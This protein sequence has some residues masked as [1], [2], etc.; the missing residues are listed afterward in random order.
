M[1]YLNTPAT[2]CEERDI[3]GMWKKARN[4]EIENF[5]GVDAPFDTPWSSDLRFNT[6]ELSVEHCVEK[7]I[8]I[9]FS[10]KKAPPASL[11]IGRYQ[12]LHEGHIKLIGVPLREGKRVVIALRDTQ[13]TKDNPHTIHE[14]IQ[15]FREAF[16]NDFN[17]KLTIISIPDILDVCHG[18]RVGW[19]IREI[20]MDKSTEQISATKIREEAAK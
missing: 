13:L 12:P 1:V 15:M 16:P 4:K 14:R 2:V 3:K 18:R 9:F 10:G 5:T 8:S 6:N 20:Q 19:K 11:F 7:L 17:K